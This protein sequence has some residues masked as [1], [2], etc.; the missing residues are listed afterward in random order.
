MFELR[1]GDT[2]IDRFSSGCVG[3]SLGVGNIDAG[4]NA[5]IE[6]VRCKLQ[7]LLE[8]RNRGI[9]KTLLLVQTTKLKVVKS[10]F[11]VNAQPRRLNVG[12]ACLRVRDLCLDGSAN[13]SPNV[14]L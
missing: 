11:G 5:L 4:H 1:T 7:S 14:S 2:N 6:T 9:E 10:E 8:G 3:L 13:A 12:S